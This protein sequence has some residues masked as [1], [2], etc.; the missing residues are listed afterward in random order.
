MASALPVFKRDTYRY[1]ICKGDKGMD[2]TNS[3]RNRLSQK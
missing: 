2:N 1:D 3:L